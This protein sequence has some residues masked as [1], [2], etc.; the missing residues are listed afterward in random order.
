MTANIKACSFFRETGLN[1]YIARKRATKGLQKT[2]EKVLF[3]QNSCSRHSTGPA[4][5]VTGELL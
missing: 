1:Y 2:P 3:H 5:I 4:W